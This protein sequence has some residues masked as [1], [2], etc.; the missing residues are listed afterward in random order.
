MSP[1]TELERMSL[2]GVDDVEKTAGLDFISPAETI[3]D[4]G[5]QSTQNS[6]LN[7]PGGMHA[8]QTWQPSV[9]QAD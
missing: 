3:C 2:Q 8:S 4:A 6:K 5:Q 1:G 7:V 9:Q